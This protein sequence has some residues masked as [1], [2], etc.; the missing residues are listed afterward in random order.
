MQF[1]KQ[2]EDNFKELTKTVLHMLL[3][4][5]FCSFPRVKIAS[6]QEF[7]FV[8]LNSQRGENARQREEKEKAHSQCVSDICYYVY[9]LHVREGPQ[10]PL[11]YSRKLFQQFVV[12]TWANCEQRK[13]NQTRTYQHTF[14]SELYQGLQDTAIYN[15]YN[16]KDTRPLRHKIIII[17]FYV[18]NPRF[19]TQLFQNTIAIYRYFHKPDLFLTMTANSKQPEIIYSLFPEQTATNCPDIVSYVITKS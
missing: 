4:T 15:R 8:E 11:F 14:R 2:K 12:D 5:I 6:I 9:C 19:I 1:Y 16:G 18:G 3:F 17:I 10:L 13:L 7:L